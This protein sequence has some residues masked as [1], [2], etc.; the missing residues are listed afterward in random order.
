MQ[1]LRAA[2]L[3]QGRF[4]LEA[5]FDLEL[6]VVQGQG[7]GGLLQGR[8]S[9]IWATRHGLW[10]EVCVGRGQMGFGKIAMIWEGI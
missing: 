6:A 4:D 3:G 1:T 10:G 7:A 5:S 2:G 8:W 9:T